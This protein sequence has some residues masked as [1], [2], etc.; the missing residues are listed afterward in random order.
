M[1]SKMNAQ[2]YNCEKVRENCYCEDANDDDACE[3][4][5]F[6]AAGLDYCQQEGDNNGE[7]KNQFNLQEA[8]ECRRME[9]DE[10][11]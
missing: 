10:G 9:V 2:E 4:T 8:V 1:E 7:N 6:A 3:A 5:C 11:T